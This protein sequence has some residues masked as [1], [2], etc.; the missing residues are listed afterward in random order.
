[1]G[2]SIINPFSRMGFSGGAQIVANRNP[3]TISAISPDTGGVGQTSY[4]VTITGTRLNRAGLAI[5]I[6]GV[7]VSSVVPASD[8]LTATG[9]VNLSTLT[10]DTAY[11]VVVSTNGGSATLAGGF[12]VRAMTVIHAL[13]TLTG[14]TAFDTTANV[15]SGIVS[16]KLKF[17]T[18]DTVN[19][20]E[21]WLI[22]GQSF[23]GAFDRA[24][25][26]P[27]LTMVTSSG[28]RIAHHVFRMSRADLGKI[29]VVGYGYETG[30]LDPAF[31][32][33]TGYRVW[34]YD[35][36]TNVELGFVSA[37]VSSGIKLRLKG[38]ATRAALL[39][40]YWSAGAWVQL[41]SGDQSA[42]F[43]G[44]TLIPSMGYSGGSAL[45]GDISNFSNYGSI[46]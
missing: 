2:Q 26:I 31:T 19:G 46:A 4:S 8:G 30:I 45:A 37:A 28:S 41:Y 9:T 13:N 1:M 12:T 39:V 5:T 40:Y 44:E 32:D 20:N 29:L 38:D 15:T 25:E 34:T 42:L 11:D 14:L 23:A 3:P 24:L 7:S 35:G 10:V 36:A 16:G 27:S 43:N 18:T 21:T 22:D 17:E 33:G 6:G